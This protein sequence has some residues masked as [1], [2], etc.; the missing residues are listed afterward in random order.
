MR[1]AHPVAACTWLVGM[2]ACMATTTDST[3]TVDG[4]PEALVADEIRM[5]HD[6]YL[7]VC[8]EQTG[9][10]ADKDL[11]RAAVEDSWMRHSRIAFSGWGRCNGSQPGIHITIE[12]GANPNPTMTPLYGWP[13]Q[14]ATPSQGDWGLGGD[15]NGIADLRLTFDF[16]AQSTNF[17]N[18]TANETSRRNCIR[19]IA[20]HEFGHALAFAHEQDR[21]DTPVSCVNELDLDYSGA[22]QGLESEWHLGPFDQESIM[23]YCASTWNNAGK[24][25]PNDIFY[26]QRAYGKKTSGDLVSF[27]GRC[28][29]FGDGNRNGSLAQAYE[30]LGGTHF[31]PGEV[32]APNQRL[33]FDPR[34]STL[35]LFNT[36]RV[37]D[38]PNNDASNGK[39]LQLFDSLNAPGQK[40]AMPN[41]QL[42]GLGAMCVAPIQNGAGTELALFKCDPATAS[43]NVTFD[44]NANGSLVHAGSGMCIEA[45]GGSKAR[46]Q[47]Q[48]CNS[49]QSQKWRLAANGS[50]EAYDGTMGLCMDVGVPNADLDKFYGTDK[51]NRLQTYTCNAQANQQFS[52]AGPIVGQGGKCV[53]VASSQR[54]NGTAVQLMDCN[55]NANQVWELYW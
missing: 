6:P 10:N 45:T 20:V 31:A 54:A 15:P 3:Q 34:T 53:E 40:W 50:L 25:S 19:S 39:R 48:P 4:Q 7:S 42:R 5:W 36:N 9:F 52:L 35:G 26:T 55:G 23:A 43:S 13:R 44:I 37:L 27:D 16:Q 17:S 51:Y 28:L 11:V 2:T 49:N 8:W 14:V 18:C 32:A 24:L 38:V 47:L 22:G 30:C 21:T 12:N 46:L 33:W 41:A 1:F 29:D